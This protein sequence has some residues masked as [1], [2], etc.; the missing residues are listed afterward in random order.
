MSRDS[1]AN[2]RDSGKKQ[3]SLVFFTHRRLKRDPAKL[4]RAAHK[5]CLLVEE[6][7]RM[8]LTLP[9]LEDD[10]EALI[11][12]KQRRGTHVGEVILLYLLVS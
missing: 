12:T 1:G 5:G 10:L 4:R 6:P 3:G 11:N 7:V 2:L 8:C 9:I